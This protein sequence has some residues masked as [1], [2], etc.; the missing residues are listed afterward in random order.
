VVFLG[1]QDGYVYALDALQGGNAPLPWPPSLVSGGKVVQAAPAG[2]FQA[3]TG[4]YDYLLVG[5][6]EDGVDNVFAAI[7]PLPPGNVLATFDNGGAGSGIGIISGMATVEY[8]SPP[9]VYFTSRARVGGSA[10]TLWCLQLTGTPIV[11]TSCPGWTSPTLGD[12]DASP[13]LRGGRIYVGS[14]A[15]GGTVYSVDAASG[16]ADRSYVH[17]DGQVKG[18]VFP[19]RNSNDIYFATDNFVWGL[20]DDGAATMGLKFG[21]G[22][23]LGT[24]VKPSAALFVPG[25]HFVYA[26]GSDGSLYVIDLAGAPDVTAIP[27]GDGK[28]VVGA[29]SLD[30]GYVPN[31]VHVGTEAGIFYAVE[32]PLP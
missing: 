26:G 4:D 32:V 28:S 1:A 24:G 21:G 14:S 27:L 25:S 5:T 2:V 8:A 10:N 13:V 17:G 23:S 18:F 11:F 30:R 19:D 7:D 29:P 6:R 3:F 9:R 16:A 12:I 15:G 22:V 31:L 20:T